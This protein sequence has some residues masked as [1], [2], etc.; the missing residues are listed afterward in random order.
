MLRAN[1]HTHTK[2]CDGDNTAEEMVQRALDLG[3]EHLGFSG[4][5]DPDIH[6][7]WPSYV[8]EID[9]LKKKYAAQ[10]DIIMGVEL[11]NVYDPASCPGAEYI[12][13]STHFLPVETP[14]P[15]S[16]DNTAEMLE[17]LCR[18]YYGGDWYRL[19]RA[20]YD[21]E[22]QVFDRTRCTFVGHFDLVTRFNDQMHAFDE[23]DSRYTGPALEAM[24]HLVE[25][26]V[27]F[28]INCGAINRGRKAEPYPRQELLVALRE[29][30]GEILIN[31]DAHQA[32]RLN[33]GFDVAVERAIAAGF[34]HV[35][36]LAHDVTGGLEFRQL[37]L[38]TL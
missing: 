21:L 5:M 31:S 26:G 4:H 9:R 34:T 7:D 38:D 19:T 10:L 33:G 11:D 24:E 18:D 32:E 29:F 22:A 6:M 16:V 25:Q 15:M 1:Y 27:P 20:Y 12:I 3:F 14:V 23:G 13:G 17:E 37:S 30:G 28:E 2:F 35:N 8:A 36:I